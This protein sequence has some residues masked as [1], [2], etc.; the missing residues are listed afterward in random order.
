MQKSIHEIVRT[1]CVT[2]RANL[3]SR[4]PSLNAWP[5]ELFDL[6]EDQVPDW[7]TE[8]DEEQGPWY[9][10]CDLTVLQ[11]GANELDEVDESVGEFAGLT[12]LELQHN[13]LY[14]LPDSMSNLQQ[15]TALNIARNQL[16]AFPACLLSLEHLASLDVSHNKIASLWTMDG[17]PMPA[18]RTLDLSH[19]RLTLDALTGP[20][21]LALA[22]PTHLRRLD[23]SD[24]AIKGS[25]PLHLFFPLTALEELDLEGN[26]LS[27]AVFALPE[28]D[29]SVSPALPALRV[30]GLRRTPLAS[31]APLESLFNSGTSL[32]MDE[33]RDKQRMPLHSAGAPAAPIFAHQLLR[34]AVRPSNAELE[35]APIAVLGPGK[36]PRTLPLLFVVLD[37]LLVKPESTR[38]RRARAK[39]SDSARRRDEHCNDTAQDAGSALANAK[40]STKKKEALGQV[41][42]KFFRNNGCSAGDACPFAHTFPAEGQQKAVC[43]WYVKGSCRFGHRCALAHIMPGQPMSMDRK[44]KRA[45]QQNTRPDE[46]PDE[47]GGR[48]H[49]TPILPP[50]PDA[51]FVP[52]A[53]MPKEDDATSSLSSS[54]RNAKLHNGSRSAWDADPARAS[55]DAAMLGFGTSPFSYPG[56]H[57]LF[58][59]TN[60]EPAAPNAPN[61]PAESL[62]SVPRTD[63]PLAEHAEDFLPSSLSDLLTNAERERRTLHTRD[64]TS[65]PVVLGH[66]SQ[67]LPSRGFELDALQDI[68]PPAYKHSRMFNSTN[69]RIGAQGMPGSVNAPKNVHASPF[70]APVISPTLSPPGA[71]G[72]RSF[73]LYGARFAPEEGTRRAGNYG[74]DRFHTPSSPAILPRTDDADDAIFEL[75]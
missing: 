7:Y 32:L 67:S 11:L 43:Q 5:E 1:A 25:L 48:T 33:A 14:T 65:R 41:P 23:L 49:G 20:R 12:W 40:L 70:L 63:D 19:N 68:S 69:G 22:L 57:G 13:L 17:A 66:A 29:A 21:A 47:K 6:L 54:L 74:R 26:E 58:F 73:S 53:R 2:G 31:L 36:V 16:T 38:K 10:R 51:V 72:D 8:G 59:N 37:Q 4:F 61:A 46:R 34:T 24:N 9:N 44:N 55:H 52:G 56:S 27:D 15:L 71:I 45:S 28:R 18:L 30:L 35:M 50:A 75:E 60:K 3:A 39:E 42:C 64:T 62:W